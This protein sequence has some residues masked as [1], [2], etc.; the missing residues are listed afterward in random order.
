[1]IPVSSALIVVAE[2]THL[3]D[4]LQARERTVAA[5]ALADGLH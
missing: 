1:V 4:L 5:T 2:I 3:V